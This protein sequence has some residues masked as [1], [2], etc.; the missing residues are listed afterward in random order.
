MPVLVQRV[1]RPQYT[2]PNAVTT[3]ARGRRR[4]SADVRK[5]HAHG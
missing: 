3:A 1:P 4:A 2:H 5:P